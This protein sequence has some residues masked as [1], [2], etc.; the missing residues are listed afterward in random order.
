LVVP[1]PLDLPAS[2]LGAADAHTSALSRLL[3]AAGLPTIDNDGLIATSCRLLGIA[4]QSD[5]PIAPWLARAS[6]IAP[7]DAYWICAEPATLAVG[8][9]DVRLSGIVD[10]LAVQDTEALVAMLN[11]HFADDA[12]HFVA[13]TPRQW[14]ARV[15]R[16]QRLETRPPEAALGAPLFAFMPAGADAARWRCWQNEMQMLLFEH[17]ANRRREQAGRPL[18]NSVWLWG[19]GTANPERGAATG[20]LFA[21]GGRVRDLARGSGVEVTPVPAGFEALPRTGTAAVWLAPFD[22]GNAIEQLGGIDRTW[23][24]PVERALNAGRLSEVDLILGARERAFHFALRRS[25]LA[26]RWR[27]KFSPPRLSHLL[28]G[29]VFDPDTAADRVVDPFHKA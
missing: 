7:D 27:A 28:A 9:A 12:V 3:A 1:G 4:K 20:A 23:M 21:D 13:P 18:V 6:G 2:V 8:Q 16:A 24:A 17:P 11:A 26:R 22:R 29:T 10:D 19:G 14:F 25:S 15:P 5:W